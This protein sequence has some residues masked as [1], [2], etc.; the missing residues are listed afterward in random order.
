MMIEMKKNCDFKTSRIY[1]KQEN[2][3]NVTHS[4][5]LSKWVMKLALI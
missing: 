5:L 1:G 3:K 4:V 2:S